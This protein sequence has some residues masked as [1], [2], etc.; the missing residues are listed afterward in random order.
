MT[1]YVYVCGECT[2]CAITTDERLSNRL[3]CPNCDAEIDLAD[4]TPDVRDDEIEQADYGVSDMWDY[5]GDV[6]VSHSETPEET[7]TN[8][9]DYSYCEY[10]PLINIAPERSF[11]ANVCPLHMIGEIRHH[12]SHDPVNSQIDLIS[13]DEVIDY[14]DTDISKEISWVEIWRIL[15][16]LN[17]PDGIAVCKN[18]VRQFTIVGNDT[19]TS[20]NEPYMKDLALRTFDR[21]RDREDNE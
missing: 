20:V 5:K 17:D 19:I 1:E 14:E 9:C 18:D 15:D 4:E 13:T 12:A 3:S 7:Q 2:D 11:S 8:T 10:L 21:I 16:E 6:K